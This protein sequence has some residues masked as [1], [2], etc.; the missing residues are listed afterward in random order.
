M[1]PISAAFRDQPESPVERAV[2]WTEYVIR[3]Q[4]AVHLRSPELDLSWIQLLHLDILFLMHLAIFLFIKFLR[5]SIRLFCKKEK[6][7]KLKKN[8]SSKIWNIWPQISC[9]FIML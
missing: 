6:R 3:Y 4:G 9:N 1:I 7:E 8:W 2:Y 5:K